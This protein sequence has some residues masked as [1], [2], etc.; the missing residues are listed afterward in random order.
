MLEKT[1]HDLQ[2][3]DEHER[4]EKRGEMIIERHQ[5]EDDAEPA[6]P[7][8][9]PAEIVADMH[10]RRAEVLDDI[11][12]LEDILRAKFDVRS[13]VRHWIWRGEARGLDA[14]AA[15]LE[16]VRR[17]PA[18]VMAAGVALLVGAVWLRRR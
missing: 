14:A 11:S 10:A 2:L 4:S 12:Q 13:R 8:R 16:I 1:R 6:E 17:H 9:E 3:A 18:P 15:A 7:K 5:R